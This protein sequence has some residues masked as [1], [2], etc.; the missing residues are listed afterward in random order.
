M[1]SAIWACKRPSRLCNS[2]RSGSSGEVTGR[3]RARKRAATPDKHRLRRRCLS[4]QA[5]ATASGRLR[6]AAKRLVGAA[7]SDISSGS[8]LDPDVPGSGASPAVSGGGNSDRRLAALLSRRAVPSAERYDLC[9]RSSVAVACRGAGTSSSTCAVAGCAVLE[10]PSA[11]TTGAS[12]SSTSPSRSD[13][14]RSEAMPGDMAH[15]LF[16]QDLLHAAN[17]HAFVMQQ[18]PDPG[19]QRHIGGAVIAPPAR[20]LDRLD[21]RKPAFP[22][23][24][25]MRRGF[26][27]SATS[28]MVRKASGDLSI[29]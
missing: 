14:H 29:R 8:C 24:Q 6:L 21:L 25:H 11:S 7:A 12:P 17:G 15:A 5:S 19:Q 3:G 9:R 4:V 2:M 23:P 16:A 22:E 27:A 13:R 18:T 28:E 26:Q 20:A 10:P 1:A